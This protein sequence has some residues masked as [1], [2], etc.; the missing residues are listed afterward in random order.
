MWY[1]E[2]MET[3]AMTTID[4]PK[5]LT[6]LWQE[7]GLG[8]APFRFITCIS[9]P[10][11]ALCEANPNAYNGQMAEAHHSAEGF[12]V[13]LCTCYS[14]GMSLNHNYVIRDKNGKHFVVGSDCVGKTYDAKLIAEVELAEKRRLAAV[15]EAKRL[16]DAAEYARLHQLNLAAQRQANGGLTDS[17]LL[18]QKQ[19]DERLAKEAAMHDRNRWLIT[20]INAV[21]YHS[22]FLI[23]M[24]ESLSR[25]T[26]KELP[27]KCRNILADVYAKQIT[28]GAKRGSKKYDTACDEFFTKLEA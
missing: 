19:L 3:T 24:R 2:A 28:D 5:V 21:P 12:G 7:Q 15:R 4:S 25:V 20:V 26:V 8:V 18:Q 10:S 27:E 14:C 1:S 13:H 11:K 23:S 6:H 17:E 9:I 22:D 16:A